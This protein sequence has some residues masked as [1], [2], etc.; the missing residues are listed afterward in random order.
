M[1]VLMAS[2]CDKINTEISAPWDASLDGSQRGVL[3]T[4]FGGVEL[5]RVDK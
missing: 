5:L 1:P 2:T 3:G 4:L